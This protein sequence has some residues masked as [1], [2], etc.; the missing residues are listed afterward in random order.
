MITQDILDMIKNPSFNLDEVLKQY[1]SNA[2]NMTIISKYNMI[3][4]SLIML[5][6]LD[7]TFVIL[8]IQ[9]LKDLSLCSVYFNFW[10]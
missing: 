2:N 6:N 10:F 5:E 7:L 1:T 4:I 8:L 9:Q 3:K